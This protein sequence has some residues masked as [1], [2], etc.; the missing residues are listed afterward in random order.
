V[1][2]RGPPATLRGG[3]AT[4]EGSPGLLGSL[5]LSWPT[6]PT[7]PPKPALWAARPRVRPGHLTALAR[8]R[9]R[10][11]TYANGLEHEVLSFPA[12]AIEL[13]KY[14]RAPIDDVFAFF[15][16]PANT[17]EFNEHAVRFE[18][19]N[20]QPDGRR[21]FD[22]LM[23]AGAKEWMQ[24]IEEVVRQQPTRLWTRG[25]SW[26]TVRGEWILTVTT[27]RRFSTEDDGTRAYVTIETSP[28]H[29]FRH[30]FRVILNWI[31]Q[32]AARTAFERQLDAIAARIEGVAGP[33]RPAPRH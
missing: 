12:M 26:N 23:R 33:D 8:L 27:D 7:S 11:G 10:W 30:P 5:G 6:W 24:T 1:K 2:R 15:A 31:Q 16:D 3:G 4:G 25:G 18:V 13:T 21:T 29:P 17:V 22:V 9:T 20:A 28:A 14:I 19:V 32:G